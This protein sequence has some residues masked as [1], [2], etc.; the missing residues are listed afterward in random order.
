MK[1]FV[2]AMAMWLC[3]VAAQPCQVFSATVKEAGEVGRW[4]SAKFLGKSQSVPE[5]ACLLVYTRNGLIEKNTIAGQPLRIAAE[6]Y[7]RADQVRRLTRRRG[8]NVPVSTGIPKQ[9][10]QANELSRNWRLRLGRVLCAKLRAPI[11]H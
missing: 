1:A 2:A 4:V 5:D 10:F 11:R 7:Q 3:C 8:Q 6:Q 9:H